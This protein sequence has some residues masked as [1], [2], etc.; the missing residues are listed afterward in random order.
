MIVF[1]GIRKT[2]QKG[3]FLKVDSV[4]QMCFYKMDEHQLPS[5]IKGFS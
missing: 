2:G 1:S 3:L 4:Q 5:K